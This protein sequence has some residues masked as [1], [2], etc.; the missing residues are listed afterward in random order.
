MNITTK[1]W[2]ALVAC[3]LAMAVLGAAPAS[4]D[5]PEPVETIEVSG[6]ETLVPEE[7]ARVGDGDPTSSTWLN[8]PSTPH[9]S[10]VEY[11]YLS[12]SE[13]HDGDNALECAQKILTFMK[14]EI[15]QLDDHPNSTYTYQLRAR[16]YS[17]VLDMTSPYEVF[18]DNIHLTVT[19]LAGLSHTAEDAP[20]GV[21]SCYV[22][23]YLLM[24]RCVDDGAGGI[25]LR[26]EDGSAVMNTFTNPPQPVYL[27][28]SGALVSQGA[29]TT[30][31]SVYLQS[32]NNAVLY[33]GDDLVEHHE[34]VH[35][36]QWAKWDWDFVGLYAGES[37]GQQFRS[38][39]YFFLTGSRYDAFCFNQYEQAAKFTDGNYVCPA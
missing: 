29:A 18:L 16:L 27:P 4:A 30:Y 15:D 6:Q 38:D 26:N 3:C 10:N 34:Q 32:P 19:L 7:C 20:T 1:V 37:L 12:S 31:A 17:G 9:W 13:D 11:G 14:W 24:V 35:A 39:L 23:D 21:G 22:T 28:L 5:E 2:A 33:P 8:V 36:Q 25:L